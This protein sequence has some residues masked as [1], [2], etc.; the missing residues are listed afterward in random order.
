MCS[1]K[2]SNIRRTINLRLNENGSRKDRPRQMEA[3][4][5]KHPQA[6]RQMEARQQLMSIQELSEELEAAKNS[7]QEKESQLYGAWNA[8][9]EQ[10]MTI[11]KL[12]EELK[13]VK[14]SLR[15]KEASK[16]GRM[17]VA[18]IRSDTD[19]K[20]YTMDIQHTM[21]NISYIFRIYYTEHSFVGRYDFL[22]GRNVL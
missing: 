3:P 16:R 21:G 13:A 11:S 5:E 10:E 1:T 8:L 7:L 17:R 14:N 20:Q 2:Y 15:D 9:R 6:P 22:G 18:R 12:S 19:L 4:R